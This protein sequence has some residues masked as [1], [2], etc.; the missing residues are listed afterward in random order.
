MCQW[1]SRE[2]QSPPALAHIA[3]LAKFREGIRQAGPDGVTFEEPE[4]SGH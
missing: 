2:R 1:E 3:S 4:R